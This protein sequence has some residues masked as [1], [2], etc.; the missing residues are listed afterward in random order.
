MGA[1]DWFGGGGS[2]D[3]ATCG[4][5][6]AKCM[7]G[8]APLALWIRAWKLEPLPCQRGRWRS[9]SCA[10]ELG[11]KHKILDLDSVDS[12]CRKLSECDSF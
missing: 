1:G 3:D 10:V 11:R 9:Y 8:A 6:N 12:S 7:E 2:G 5:R 4:I